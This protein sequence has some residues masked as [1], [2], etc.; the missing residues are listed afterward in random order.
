MLSSMVVCVCVCM[1]LRGCVCVCRCVYVTALF[2][3]L[4]VLFNAELSPEGYWCVFCVS[5]ITTVLCEVLRPYSVVMYGFAPYK[6]H[7]TVCD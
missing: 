1:C 6:Y 4:L 7:L 2:V 5:N 3:C